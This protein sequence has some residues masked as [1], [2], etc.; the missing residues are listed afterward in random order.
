MRHRTRGR[1]PAGRSLNS[2]AGGGATHPALVTSVF[3]HWAFD[4]S[5]SVDRTGVNG[6]VLSV[7][8]T[9]GAA[10]A[11]VGANAANF[12]GTVANYL[13]GPTGSWA[14]F[15]DIEWAVGFWY[16]GGGTSGAVFAKDNDGSQ[17][18]REYLVYNNDGAHLNLLVFDA[19]GN[20]TVG[21]VAVS[22]SAYHYVVCARAKANGTLGATAALGI[23]V[24]GGAYTTANYTATPQI[25]STQLRV[26]GRV[27]GNLPMTGRLDEL[28]VW[29]GYVPT[30]TD[31]ATVYNGGSGLAYPWGL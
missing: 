9:V 26:G 23:S 17:A 18:T 5:S 3:D 10:T 16:F 27:S 20:G 7:N 8:G 31:I 14:N 12:D 21:P 13:S 19:S 25:T 4:E 22:A 28:T 24:D 29:K 30:V 2:V 11:K 6:T 15:G 1:R